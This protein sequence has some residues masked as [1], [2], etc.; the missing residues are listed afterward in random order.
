MSRAGLVGPARPRRFAALGGLALQVGDLLGL[1]VGALLVARELV[2][3]LA[4]ALLLAS[5]A[6]QRRVV[7]DVAGGLLGQRTRG[8]PSMSLIDKITGRAKKAAGDIA[9]DAS[10][11][12]QGRQEERKGEAKDELARDQAR[13]D[14]QGRR[15][16]QPGAQDLLAPRIAWAGLAR[17]GRLGSFSRFFA[18]GRTRPAP[19]TPAL[20]HVGAAA[21]TSTAP[22][23]P[24]L[25]TE[26]CHARSGCA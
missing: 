9:D 19:P 15:G 5:L 7:G 20:D 25:T 4:L 18:G 26:P 21:K 14:A 17:R 3:G 24:R 13:A 16:R 11:R 23:A 10:L 8:A 12:R 2:L 1:R 6:A 22:P